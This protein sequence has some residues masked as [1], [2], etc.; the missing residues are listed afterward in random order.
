MTR[1]NYTCTEQPAVV[2]DFLEHLV[3]TLA[4]SEVWVRRQAFANLAGQLIEIGAMSPPQFA[5]HILP[6]LLALSKDKVPNVRL[7]VA[8]TIVM[9]I[10]NQ[11]EGTLITPHSHYSGIC[12]NFGI[13]L[14]EYFQY[15]ADPA[16]PAHDLLR[17]TL[18]ELQE[19]E[20]RD[21][22]YSSQLPEDDELLTT[23]E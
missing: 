23:V 20:D 16:L 5:Q 2:K 19:D 1:L 22:R 6:S 13:C 7:K 3:K 8:E 15:F 14:V 18:L 9:N 11:G 21:V 10:I 12:A 4:Q 17:N